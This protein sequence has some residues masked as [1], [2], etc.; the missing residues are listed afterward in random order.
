MENSEHDFNRI[1][2]KVSIVIPSWFT[3]SQHGRYGEHETY[4][5]AAKCLQRLLEVTP[6]KMYELIII[7]NGS[8]LTSDVFRKSALANE[9]ESQYT[10]PEFYFQQANILIRNKKNLGFAP[11]INQGINIARGEYIASLNN[12]ILVWDGW[13]DGLINVFNTGLTPPVGMVMPALIKNTC[14]GNNLKDARIALKL[15]KKDVDMKT[16]AGRYSPGAEFGSLWIAKKTLLKQIA[17]KRGGYQILDENFKLGMGEDR[18][19][20]REIRKMGYD[21]YRCHEVRVFHQ[22]NMTIGKFPNRRNYTIPN[23]E[24]LS[25]VIESNDLGKYKY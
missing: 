2:P 20:Y 15:T 8:S 10:D 24:Y 3:V 19:A 23:R 13:L 14:L 25:K 6:H 21:T 11:S 5:F 12:D 7:D 16:N 1:I 17:E 22:G 4:W 18:L 9:L